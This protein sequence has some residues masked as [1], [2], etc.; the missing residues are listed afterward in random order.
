[1][2][3]HCHDPQC[4]SGT[5]AHQAA[6]RHGKQCHLHGGLGRQFREC[7]NL[8][9][10]AHARR[11][12]QFAC[13]HRISVTCTAVAEAAPEIAERGEHTAAHVIWRDKTLLTNSHLHCMQPPWQQQPCK[14]N[15]MLLKS[16]TTAHVFLEPTL[17][18]LSL[19]KMPSKKPCFWEQL[20]QV[21][22]CDASCRLISQSLPSLCSILSRTLSR[23]LHTPRQICTGQMVNLQASA[24][25]GLGGIAIAGR[26]GTAKSVMARG[27]HQLLPPIEVVDGSWC[28]ANPDTPREWEVGL[29]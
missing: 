13:R 21:Q 9:Q 2:M 8:L 15:K 24:N 19:G 6:A 29:C 1:M 12:N 17:W 23:S 14:T 7:R 27:L 20:T 25:A 18:Q 5:N 28:N 11:H 26:R 3:P 22:I 10:K 4:L 16:A